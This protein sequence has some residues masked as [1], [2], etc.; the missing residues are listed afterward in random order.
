[1]GVVY[2]IRMCAFLSG[3]CQTACWRLCLRSPLFSG[4][5]ASNFRTIQASSPACYKTGNVSVH[6]SRYAI[7]EWPGHSNIMNRFPNSCHPP[8]KPY[9]DYYAGEGCTGIDN[10]VALDT[11][12]LAVTT[13][14]TAAD[15]R[16]HLPEAQ[17]AQSIAAYRAVMAGGPASSGEGTPASFVSLSSFLWSRSLVFSKSQWDQCNW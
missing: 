5:S 2:Y 17:A 7:N 14:T 9:F 16:A 4:T 11:D 1:M 15:Q 6:C 8:D 3:S 10:S 13:P 12:C